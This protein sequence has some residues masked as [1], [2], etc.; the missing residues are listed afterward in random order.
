MVS[1]FCTVVALPLKWNYSPW[2]GHLV[3]TVFHINVIK[4][5][6]I[7]MFLCSYIQMH[8]TMPRCLCCSTCRHEAAPQCPDDTVDYS[9]QYSWAFG[10]LFNLLA[11]GMFVKCHMMHAHWY[12]VAVCCDLIL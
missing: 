9:M 10:M 12:E 11:S 4:C 1:R 8:P 3:L 7:T 2:L 5:N 6:W